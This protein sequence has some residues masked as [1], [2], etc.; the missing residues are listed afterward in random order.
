MSDAQ[1]MQHTYI[2]ATLE[3][4][5]DRLGAYEDLRSTLGFAPWVARV[6]EDTE[7]IG[8]GG[9]SL[10]PEE[11]E[12]GLEVSY[13][14]SPSAWSKGYAIE[15]VQ[16]SL[17]YAF[18]PLCAHEVNAFAKK[19]SAASVRVLEKSGFSLLR[20]EPRLK[21]NHYLAAVPSAA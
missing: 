19:E 5:S 18:G 4:C 16:V 14:F 21:R 10:D 15:L 2:A 8:W 17:A 3:Q 6:D 20:Y 7:P 1:A 12:W 9:L 11:P 13:A